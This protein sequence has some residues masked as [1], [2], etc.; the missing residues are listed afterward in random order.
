MAAVAQEVRSA[1][2]HGT[3]RCHDRSGGPTGAK[4]KAF[5]AVIPNAS[6]DQYRIEHQQNRRREGIVEVAGR[7]NGEQ[8]TGDEEA[9]RKMPFG[10][11]YQQEQGN[12]DKSND[13][14]QRY[15]PGQIA[16]RCH[17]RFPTHA[18][19]VD[20]DLHHPDTLDLLRHSQEQ[21]TGR[22]PAHVDPVDTD[23][24]VSDGEPG[25]T[26]G[27]LQLH[28]DGVGLRVERRGSAE[29]QFGMPCR[30]SLPADLTMPNTQMG[31]K[32][33]MRSQSMKPNRLTATRRGRSRFRDR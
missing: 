12:A 6:G 19:T 16:D 5:H 22:Q 17:S 4:S 18:V 24:A 11:A 23:N 14:R 27:V 29:P 7:T 30:A 1:G 13:E 15:P 10:G 28:D 20:R 25:G 31:T 21:T 32:V 8:H 26:A 33:P 9:P 3:A 2:T